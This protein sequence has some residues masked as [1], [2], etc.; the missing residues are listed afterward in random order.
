MKHRAWFQSNFIKLTTQG[1]KPLE[2][3]LT[4]FKKLYMGEWKIATLENKLR[5]TVLRGDS[6]TE[7]EMRMHYAAF[8]VVVN[9]L[10]F[11]DPYRPDRQFLHDF[12]MS[13]PYNNQ[14]FMGND[15][16]SEKSIDGIYQLALS[17]VKPKAHSTYNNRSHTPRERHEEVGVNAIQHQRGRPKTTDEANAREIQ[18]FHC[19]HKGHYTGK[20]HL[21]NDE[22]S[23]KGKQLWAA[24]NAAAGRA[25][26]YDKHYYIA[27]SKA[28]EEG[29]DRYAAMNAGRV[30]SRSRS[31]GDGSSSS[32]SSS[33]S[34]GQRGRGGRNR[35]G[36]SG[37][38]RRG[39]GR[40]GG[41]S[42]A[43]S[44]AVSDSDSEDSDVVVVEKED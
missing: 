21:I 19:G 28:M 34:S 29:K 10:R 8:M 24:R 17:S 4:E 26:P 11:C 44:Q 33:S 27:Y 37:G 9:E 39:R 16:K 23:N 41:G 5:A 32:S 14:V 43:N 38:R 42:S 6:V 36:G 30:A 20:C 40:G 15:W 18:C 7:A 22:Q 31:R 13:L 2:I 3:F 25:Y 35:H 12:Y 1:V